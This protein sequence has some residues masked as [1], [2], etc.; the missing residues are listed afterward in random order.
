MFIELVV[1][2]FYNVL[3]INLSISWGDLGIFV[4]IKDQG[5]LEG[6]TCP[7]INNP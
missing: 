3:F 7:N 6:E 4:T 5:D 1:H 2:G